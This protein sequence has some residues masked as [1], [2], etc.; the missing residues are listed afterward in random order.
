MNL[1]KSALQLIASRAFKSVL[2]FLAVVI[3]SRELGASALGIYYPFLALLGILSI[4]ANFGINGATE[5]RISEGKNKSE[6]L[7]TALAVKVPLALAICILIYAGRDYVNLYLG[8][9]L[10]LLLAFTLFLDQIGGLSLPVLRGEL[11]VGVTSVI[12]I[13]RPLG[14]LVVGL[15]LH[16]VGYGVTGLVYGYLIG[17]LAI[18]LIGWWKVS[19]EIGRPTYKQA[20]S[21]LNFG[22]YSL[23]LVL[24]GYIFSWID[25]SILTLFSISNP[26]I[27]RAEIGAYENAWRLSLIVIMASR[28]ISTTIFPQF[29]QWDS[30]DATNQIEKVIPK[31]ALPSILI[32]IPS[33]IGIS[34]ISKDLLR[35]LFGQEF[36]VAWLALIILS[37]GMILQS[38]HGIIAKPLQ[39][40][41]RPDLSAY[42]TVISILTN[43][44]L[45]I[46]LIWKYGIEGAAIATSISFSVNTLLHIRYLRGFLNIK[47]P[48]R[49]AVWSLV[50]SVVMGVC[51]YGLRLIVSMESIFDL[52]LLVFCAIVVYSVII[53]MYSPIRNNLF[54][55]IKQ[56]MS[57]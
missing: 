21:L 48:L 22:K 7:G 15:A 13:L 32:V 49:E 52:L 11:R 44:I 50:A 43:I 28:A 19:I 53:L 47:L 29:S 14:W 5:K 55:T 23:I 26:S 57:D 18:L 9:D 51:V 35:I 30:Q 1:V 3:F 8:A 4:P 2:G 36:T 46:I 54:Q 34:I 10:A 31:A 42:A 12:E 45:N 24:G 27:T 20:Q 16:T 56:S 17:T 39:A 38:I 25:V 40:L 41:N 33:F 6:Y 37:G